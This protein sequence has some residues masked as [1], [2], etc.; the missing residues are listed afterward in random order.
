MKFV[1]VPVLA[2]AL[3]LLPG[4]APAAEDLDSSWYMAMAVGAMRYQQ[5]GLQ[6][7]DLN[8]YRLVL[9]KNLNRNFAVEAHAGT[10]S[11]DTQQVYGLPVNLSVDYYVAGFLRANLTFAPQLWDNNR[12]RLYGMLGGTFIE[13]TSSDPVTTRSGSQGSIAAG[14]GMEIF[15][16]NL[17][18]QIGYTRYVHESNNDNDY[19][20]DSAHLGFI[21]EFSNMFD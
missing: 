17:G 1:L 16:D 8:D 7:Y 20:L 18:I 14:V 3:C 2:C 15:V 4:P 5:D 11:D 6:D 12:L 10:G 9:G 13:T 21:Y 19:S